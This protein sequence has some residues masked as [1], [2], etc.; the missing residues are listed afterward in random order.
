MKLKISGTS[1]LLPKN[2]CW[3]KLS[4]SYELN[5]S[6]PGQW[7]ISFLNS[8]SDDFLIQII[9]FK[10]LINTLDKENKNLII[11]K[12]FFTLLNKR[13]K[14]SNKPTIISYS[15]YDV[16][17]LLKV[18]KKISENYKNKNFFLEELYKL[19]KKFNNLYTINLDHE[20]YYEGAK[21]F[22]DKRNY[23]LANCQFSNQGIKKISKC[24]QRIVDRIKKPSAKL[25]ILDCDNTIWGG[26]VAED[27]ISGILLG[28]DGEGKLFL[29]FQK[30]V[31]KINND[32][33]LISICS[34]NNEKDVLEIFK[35]HSSM[36]LSEKDLTNPKINWNKK[37]ANILNISKELNL[38]LDSIVFWDDNPFE[39]EEVKR[40]LKGV[41]VIEVPKEKYLWPEMIMD[42]DLLS[43]INITDED[44]KKNKQYKTRSKFIEDKKNTKDDKNYLKTISL[45][46]NLLNVN[47]SNIS[48]AEQMCQKTNQF[49]L[50]SVRY[51]LHDIQRLNKDKNYTILL[52]SLKDLYGDHGIISL[53]SLRIIK[54]EII[55]IEN[56]L[57]SCR[58]LG[59]YLESWILN[60]IVKI[61]KKNNFKF[62]IGEYIKS[63]KNELVEKIYLENNFNFIENNIYL[64]KFIDKSN[65]KNTFFFDID[66]NIIPNL[67]IYE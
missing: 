32:G 25:L 23:Y 50:R 48:R 7:D 5:F 14:M 10:D 52:I 65:I 46:P 34:K 21:N 66:K 11:L 13:L 45:K 44:L 47:K 2:D 20:F 12:K 26:V 40:N 18:S 63:N 64:K 38:S 54:N 15:M 51:T 8:N 49:N 16:N 53:L 57:M 27:G 61:C 1:F 6:D 59:R 24:I 31:K 36:I 22:F 56:F 28:Q 62:I 42:I 55:F 39:R 9:C 37:S 41:N 29:D 17:N 30:A 60:E 67:E 33:I 3:T 4:K 43:K 19:N 58:I 35:N